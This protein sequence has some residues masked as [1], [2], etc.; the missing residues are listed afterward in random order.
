[1]KSI[2]SSWLLIILY[3]RSNEACAITN[4]L[5]RQADKPKDMQTF[6]HLTREPDR[7]VGIQG[8]KWE[9][10]QA[11]RQTDRQVDRKPKRAIIDKKNDY[12]D[13]K[14]ERKRDG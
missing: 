10:I 14:Q 13:I 8:T 5:N 1:M 3:E 2:A 4:H 11:N 12:E 6:S 7:H 9:G